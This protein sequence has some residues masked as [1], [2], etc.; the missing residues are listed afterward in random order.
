MK[1]TIE[2]L[3][4]ALE[5]ARRA[6]DY[7]RMEVEAAELNKKLAGSN[8][9]EVWTVRAKMTYELHMAAYQ[10]AMSLIQKSLQLAE[11][12]AMEAR[13]AG[14]TVGALY[15]E[16]NISGLLYP[17]LGKCEEGMALSSK[18]CREAEAFAAVALDEKAKTR[19]LRVAMNSYFHRIK[20]TVQHGGSPADVKRWLETVKTNSVYVALKND[21]WAVAA[22]QEAEDYLKAKG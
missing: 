22:V 8:L 16:M 1:R 6:E 15:A 4:S 19:A 20:A 7:A 11:R 13:K 3:L 5:K 21:V 10:Q 17:A 14:D 12:S 9:P 2:D 18:V